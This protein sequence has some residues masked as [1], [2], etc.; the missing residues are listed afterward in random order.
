[1]IADNGLTLADVQRVFELR[2]DVERTKAEN[3]QLKAQVADLI[4]QRDALIKLLAD[5]VAAARD[6]ASGMAYE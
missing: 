3:S 6:L 4:V 5:A 1:M 2:V